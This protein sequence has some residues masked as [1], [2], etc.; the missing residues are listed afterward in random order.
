MSV[1]LDC[2]K[3]FSTSFY[4]ILRR[5]SDNTVSFAIYLALIV[6]DSGLL[7]FIVLNTSVGLCPLG[8]KENNNNNNNNNILYIYIAQINIQED[9]IKRA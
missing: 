1:L 7:L 5:Q 6:V 8:N 3:P 2:R 4:L 9:M